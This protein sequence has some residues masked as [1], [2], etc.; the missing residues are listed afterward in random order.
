MTDIDVCIICGE[1][2][3]HGPECD[4]CEDCCQMVAEELERGIDSKEDSTD[5]KGF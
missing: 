5:M 4:C 1:E 3:T 2:P